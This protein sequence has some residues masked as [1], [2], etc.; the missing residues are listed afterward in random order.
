MYQVLRSGNVSR[1]FFLC[2][3]YRAYRNRYHV[4]KSISCVRRPPRVASRH[5]PCDQQRAELSRQGM[6]FSPSSFCPLPS[7]YRQPSFSCRFNAVP[8]F[9]SCVSLLLVVF[10]VLFLFVLPFLLFTGDHIKLVGPTVYTKTYIF[11]YF[12]YLYVVLFTMVR[13][14]IKLVEPTVYTKTYRYIFRYFY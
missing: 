10:L 8:V 3:R 7:R 1:T 13:D 2:Y 5:L 6:R 12:Y 14:H 9:M 4:S 11:R